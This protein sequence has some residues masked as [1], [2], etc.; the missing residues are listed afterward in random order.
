MPAVAVDGMRPPSPTVAAAVDPMRVSGPTLAA[1]AD[2]T[3]DPAPTLDPARMGAG[4]AMA[5]AAKTT[6][7]S[8]DCRRAPEH[9]RI[10]RRM[11]DSWRWAT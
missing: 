2:A 5:V 1:V 8:P 7:I 9:R 4:A 11:S 3:P 10:A 6:S